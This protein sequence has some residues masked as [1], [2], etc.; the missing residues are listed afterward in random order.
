MRDGK[1]RYFSDVA[2][3]R[4]IAQKTQLMS[5]SQ[6]SIHPLFLSRSDI[7]VPSA[8]LLSFLQLESPIQKTVAGCCRRRTGDQH[9]ER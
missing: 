8:Y 6:T 4:V 7:T 2:L 5:V 1:L 9:T 3:K